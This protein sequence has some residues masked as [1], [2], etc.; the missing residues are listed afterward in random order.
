M[1]GDNC[2]YAHAI[3]NRE[4]LCRGVTGPP[5]HGPRT[6][7]NDQSKIIG[8]SD[9]RTVVR[10]G[11]DV[12]HESP[13]ESACRALGSA[14]FSRFS[15]TEIPGQTLPE[16]R[17]SAHQQFRSPWKMLPRRCFTG[18]G[19]RRAFRNANYGVPH[20][21]CIA[22]LSPAHI[23]VDQRVVD[24]SCVSGYLVYL[25]LTAVH[26]S[27]QHVCGYGAGESSLSFSMIL[28]GYSLVDQ[29]SARAKD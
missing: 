10:I 20:A 26:V 25:S 28:S 5:A 8:A 2:N 7:M 21:G 16:S 19:A 27:Y 9:A 4:R 18:L 6:S 3:Y 24:H 1:Q 17:V 11:V 12:G 14:V 15:A 22:P 23:Q 13:H 29:F